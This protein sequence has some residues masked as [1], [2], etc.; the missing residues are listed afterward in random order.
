M[1]LRARMPASETPVPG[2]VGITGGAETRRPDDRPGAILLGGDHGSL[3]V[4]RSLGRRGIPVY[5]ITDDKLITKFSTYVARTL[6]W[7]GPDGAGAVDYLLNLARRDGL[8][9]WVLYPAGDREVTLVSQNHAQLSQ[10]FRLCTMP[11]A[12]LRDAVEKRRMYAKAEE[13]G[14]DYPRIYAVTRKEDLAD[15]QCQFPV[16]LKPSVKEE[17]NALTQ[18]KAWKAPNAA[19]LSAM[20]DE[21]VKLV[22][23]GSIIIQE[24]IPGSGETQFSYTGVWRDGEPV[25]SAV[26][27]RT[28]QHPVEFGTGTYVETVD[29]PEVEAAATRFLKSLS[30]SGMVEIEFKLD[31]RSGAYKILDVNPRAWTWNSIGEAVGIDF[32]Y[33]QWLLAT[34]QHAPV[35]RGPPGAAWMYVSK[36]ILAA[37]ALLRTGELGLREYLGSFRPTMRFAAFAMDDKLPGLVD[38][39]LALWSMLKRKSQRV[40]D[41]VAPMFGNDPDD[42][43]TAVK[44]GGTGIRDIVIRRGF[45]TLYFSG[46][47]SFLRPFCQGV[48]SVLMFHRV[49]PPRSEAFQPN[50]LLEITP[51]FLGQVVETLQSRNIDLVSLDEAHR[52]F[53]ERDFARPF[54]SLTFD[55]GY[56]DNKLFAYPILKKRNIPFAIYVAPDFAAGKGDL[57][58]LSLEKL[59]AER[60]QLRLR[61]RNEDVVLSCRTTA[62]KDAAYKTIYW[63]LRL[64]PSDDDIRAEIADLVVRYHVDTALSHDD[65]CMTWDELAELAADPLVTIGA[66]TMSHPILAKISEARVQAEIQKSRDEIARILGRAPLHFSYPFGDKS[67]AGPREFRIAQRLGFKTAVTTRP[68][69]LFREHGDHLMAWPRLS[70]NGKYQHR[71]FVDV[72]VSGAATAVWNRFRHVDAN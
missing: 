39:P 10:S 40:R 16:V 61:M 27:R 55:D 59:I 52:R 6:V 32:A 71:A 4:A 29:R 37:F 17:T 3:G 23:A 15:L 45:E 56:R 8:A 48:G 42:E 57:W 36:D 63:W 58:W 33:A 46:A 22:G 54:A 14:I 69:T 68:G 21:A 19:C 72:L 43:A 70:M 65:G 25:V 53:V 44:V 64:L 24:M 35:R 51:H 11:W 38:A 47:H 34:G 13:L 26:A 49:R 5:Y 67:A 12:T 20:Y 18:A 60:A 7:D 28:R 1:F 50:Q 62:E 9:G 30:F 66:H 2:T 31:R 41:F